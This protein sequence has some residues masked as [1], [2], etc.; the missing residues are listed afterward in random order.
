MTHTAT[1][2]KAPESAAR[3]LF[4]K[5]HAAHRAGRALDA[6]GGYREALALEPTLAPAHFNLGLLLRE[7]EDYGGAILS[8][9]RAARLRPGAPE[10]WLHL[11]VCRETLGDLDGAAASYREAGRLVPN[12]AAAWFNLGNV[13]K[14]RGSLARAVEAYRE[15][16]VHAPEVPEVLLN[17]GNTLRECGQL[18][19]AISLL[20]KAA[21]RKPGWPEAEWNLALARLA[22][23]QLAEGWAG[24]EAR[25]AH[26][27]LAGD[28][29]LPW[30][31]W[32]GEPLDGKEILVWRE[33][34]VGDEILFATC[35][36]DLVE[37]G[38]RVTLAV[39]DRLVSLLARAFP[40]VTVIPDRD[41][42]GRRFDYQIALGSLPR[43]VRATRGAFPE[44]WSWLLPDRARAAAWTQRLETR[45]PGFRVGI[46]WRSG[47]KTVDRLRAYSHLEQWGP[48][49]AV[50]G[51]VWV[52]LQ[53]DDCAAEL[54]EAERRFGVGIHRFDGVDL[55]NDL[56]SV[57][58]LL[59][60]LDLVITAPTAVSSLAGAM[61][62]ET[63]QL[64]HGVDWT[65][66]GEPRSP[67]F[68]AIELF[69]HD[70]AEPDWAPV[71]ERVAAALGERVRMHS[72]WNRI[73]ETE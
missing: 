33:Q 38:A 28:R 64:V 14:K 59:W 69:A 26:L 25:W 40:E 32:N 22:A 52:N 6:I 39:D 61:G 50:P 68:P 27:R 46:C 47:L 11:G 60:R 41:W 9:E 19:E 3:R 29:G 56:E 55:R 42:N 45:G 67:W 10:A 66:F 71:L 37:Q 49:F 5:A 53:Y 30:P 12:L 7:R 73:L 20:V 17:L 65:A 70:S 62:T 8:F 51:V 24:Y 18:E 58:A 54:A 2:H 34:G 4:E 35:V 16:L 48:L 57:A 44:R 43:F 13:E 72:R 31:R 21:E 1:T 23:G 36:P 63:W 15:A